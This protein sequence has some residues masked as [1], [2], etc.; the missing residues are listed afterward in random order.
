[1]GFFSNYNKVKK[2]RESLEDETNLYDL[3]EEEKE[4]VF[5]DGYEPEDFED[6]D[7]EEDDY[8]YDE[9]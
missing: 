3:T 2:E 1:M 7:L 6:E 9:R 8:Y 4:A 5:E